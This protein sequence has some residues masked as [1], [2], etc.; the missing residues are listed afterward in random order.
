[1]YNLLIVDDEATLVNSLYEYITRTHSMEYEC[2]KATSAAQALDI[3]QHIRVDIAVLDIEMP[4]MNGLELCKRLK[5]LYP[6]CHVIFLTAY[7]RFEYAYAAAQQHRTRLL[8]KTEG[9]DSVLNM[10][11]E[12]SLALDSELIRSFPTTASQANMPG[13]EKNMMPVLLRKPADKEPAQEKAELERVVKFFDSWFKDK[14][15]LFFL[16]MHREYLLFLMQ[17]LTANSSQDDLKQELELFLDKTVQASGSRMSLALADDWM[18]WND[19]SSRLTLMRETLENAPEDDDGYIWQLD[20]QALKRAGLMR[21]GDELV[22]LEQ[23]CDEDG[24]REKIHEGF[25]LTEQLDIRFAEFVFRQFERIQLKRSWN[26]WEYGY[27][28]MAQFAS[29]LEMAQSE[30]DLAAVAIE[31]ARGISQKRNLKTS[32]DLKYAVRKANDFIRQHYT[33]D[34][35]LTDIAR[36]VCL[37]SSYLSRIYKKETGMSTVDQIK[38]LRIEKAIQLL[39]TSN[40]KIQDVAMAVGYNSSRYFLA[41]F[42]S[43]VGKGPTEYREEKQ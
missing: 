4:G 19:L 12:E 14:Y 20:E 30:E 22:I 43:I 2:L 42:R 21:L 13:F 31:F 38:K 24:I 23:K 39:E 29:Q 6:H 28:Q 9:Y 10:I 7:D 17:P 41:V 18:D 32:E 36:H 27:K 35:S 34:I 33:E 16:Q 5:E 1:M 11:R 37:S 25:V 40:M 26:E 3:A 8:L 15:K